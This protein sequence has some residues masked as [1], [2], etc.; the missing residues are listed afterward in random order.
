MEVEKDRSKFKGNDDR[1]FDRGGDAGDRKQCADPRETQGTKE[2][3]RR[4]NM[5]EKPHPSSPVLCRQ[6]SSIYA[7]RSKHL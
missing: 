1:A 2:A 3:W 4:E 5:R 6:L 7:L